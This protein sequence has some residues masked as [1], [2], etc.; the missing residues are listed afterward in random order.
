M[1]NLSSNSVKNKLLQD[2][3]YS[4]RS[5]NTPMAGKILARWLLGIGVLFIIILF[6][7]WQ[8]NI[9]GTGQVTALSPSN[10]PQTA[11]RFNERR[12]RGVHAQHT[13]S[14]HRAG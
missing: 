10:R 5:L 8:Q 9:H 3:L 4:L 14:V 6:L 2:N 1:L 12:G 11:G 7:P 13:V